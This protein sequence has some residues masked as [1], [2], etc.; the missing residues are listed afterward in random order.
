MQRK[1][2][3]VYLEKKQRNLTDLEKQQIRKRLDGGERNV[4]ELAHEFGCVPTQIA[5][6][7]AWMHMK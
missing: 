1:K 5:A 7:K 2:L 4:Y 3:D 6:L